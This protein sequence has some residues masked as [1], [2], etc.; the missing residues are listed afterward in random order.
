MR[1]KVSLVTITAA[2]ILHYVI[3]YC[4]VFNAFAEVKN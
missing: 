1:M 3:Y 2:E 4:Y